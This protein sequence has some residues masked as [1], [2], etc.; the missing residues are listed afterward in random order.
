MNTPGHGRPDPADGG[1]TLIEMLFAMVLFGILTTVVLALALSTQRTTVTTER[2][3]SLNEE[4]RVAIERIS[5][6]LRQASAVTAV[7][8]DGAS[9]I[10]LTFEAD[11]NGDGVIESAG[12][13]PEVLTYRWDH[14]AGLLTITAD[15]ADGHSITRPVLA[16]KVTDFD[17]GLFGGT[18]PVATT[19]LPD[20]NRVT[21]SLTVED[22]GTR[23]YATD[24]YLRNV[25]TS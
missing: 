12:T 7:D 9:V 22:G 1:F 21:V 19:D 8:T 6:E 18:D 11:F 15:D 25:R 2:Q 10:G 20:V 23:D 5:R 17:L 13:G 3:V 16:A 4:A 24:V 14:D